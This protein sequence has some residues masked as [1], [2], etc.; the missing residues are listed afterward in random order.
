MTHTPEKPQKTGQQLR[1]EIFA[2]A[3]DSIAASGIPDGWRSRPG[4]D[5]RLWD[6]DAWEFS[7]DACST[8]GNDVHRLRFYL[9][10]YHDPVATPSRSPPGWAS[11]GRT[12]VTS[13]ARS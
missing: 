9:T 11:T 6:P 13:S 2:F 3:R 1:T 10:L 4:A 12:R 8:T 7:G 5:G